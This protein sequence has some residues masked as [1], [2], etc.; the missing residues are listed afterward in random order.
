MIGTIIG[1][2]EPP[3]VPPAEPLH[4]QRC[5][6]TGRNSVSDQPAPSTLVMPP[7]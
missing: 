1:L 5:L 6:Q 2:M 3:S 7:A 4:A